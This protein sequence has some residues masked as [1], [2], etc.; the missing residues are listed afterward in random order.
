MAA[1]RVMSEF[2]FELEQAEKDDTRLVLVAHSHG[3]M[4]TQMLMEKVRRQPWF[5]ALQSRLIIVGIG[6]PNIIPN[7]GR[8]RVYQYGTFRDPVVGLLE[9]LSR[10]PAAMRFSPELESQVAVHMGLPVQFALHPA[11]HEAVVYIKLSLL[12]SGFPAV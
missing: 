10:W 4:V 6:N 1:D 9:P 11:W 8:V 7:I 5:E 12:D 3:G 2:K